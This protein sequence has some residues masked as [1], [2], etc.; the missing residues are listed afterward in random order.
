MRALHF[1]FVALALT[2]QQT[3][4]RTGIELVQ[5]DVVV[6]DEQGRHVRGLKATD[7]ELR[8]RGKPQ[9]VAAFEEITHERPARPAVGREPIAPAA[10][11]PL[12]VANNQ[13]LQSERLV[14]LVIDDLHIWHGRTEAAKTIARSVLEKLGADASMAVLFTSGDHSTQVTQDRSVLA[15]ALDTLKGR[16]SVRRPNQAV[17]NQRGAAPSLQQF[18]DNMSLFEAIENAAAMMGRGDARRKAFV[19]VSEGLMKNPTGVF[20]TSRPPGE[21]PA[22]GDAYASGNLEAMNP[23]QTVPYH[24]LAL[25][26]M[27]ESMRRSNVATYAID[28]RGEVTAQELAYESHPEPLDGDSV[29]RWNNPIRMAQDGLTTVAEASGG[30]AVVNTDD[31]TAGIE[32]IIED[33]DH[34]YLLGFYPADP[35]K[36]GFRTLDVTVR[37]HDD[38]TVRFRHGYRTGDKPKKIEKTDELVALSAGVLPKTD[39]ALRLGAVPLAAESGSGRRVAL[40]LEV[41]VPR[42]AVEEQ[43]GRL[44][45]E[46]K[47]DVLAINERTKKVKR[48][49]GLTARATL[50]RTGSGPAPDIATYLVSDAISLEPGAYQL[51]VSAT[52]AKLKTGGSVYLQVDVPDFE[53]AAIAIGGMAL[54]YADG[55]RIASASVV[56]PQPPSQRAARVRIVL[57]E[58][59]ALPFTPTLDRVFRA[60]DTLRVY[61][62]VARKDSRA[63]LSGV[64]EVEKTDGDRAR[65][66]LP[67]T[68][69]ERGRVMLQLPMSRLAPGS[70]VLRATVTSGA[71]TATREIEISVTTTR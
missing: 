17:D 69:D 66:T 32:R 23:R 29:F 42:P 5:I 10:P 64:L 51:R 2:T 45:D 36:K 24:D 18:F 38:W 15:R 6:L 8:D 68:P 58:P 70:Y 16:Q 60:S 30:F 65:V 35:D 43:D 59:P 48:A 47:Y 37:G 3:T 54:G 53:D 13:T 49:A 57:D 14:V 12:D 40:A 11:L 4:F 56:R 55:E 9:S 71:S 20:Q 25:I 52:S 63:P 34:Y 41:S 46:L 22:G 67:F 21:T 28:P 19:L 26:D 27:M 44:R 39:L 50:S 1:A 31:F 7:F 61:F 33:L 62:E